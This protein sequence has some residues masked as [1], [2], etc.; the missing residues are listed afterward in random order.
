LAEELIIWTSAQ[1]NYV[2]LPD[3]FTTGSSIMPQKRNA[4]AAELVRGK[5]GRVIGALN[6]LLVVIKGLPLA[7]NK[8]MQEDKEPLFDAAD[9]LSVCLAA[10]IGMINGLTVNAPAMRASLAA[11]F[12]TATDLADWLVRAINMP[13]RD[14]HH[15]TGSLVKMAED[16]G[17][18][19]ADLNLAD[20]QSVAPAIT[21]AVFAVLSVD[22]SVASR[23]SFGGTA[24]ELVRA[25]AAAARARYMAST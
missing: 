25:G 15:V 21:E 10:S 11:G 24:P 22:A 8:D 2:R 4:D 23:T 9:T 6:A 12:P 3:G 18:D 7:F 14:A 13:F 16:R 19:L 20:M 5:T 1:F 17:V